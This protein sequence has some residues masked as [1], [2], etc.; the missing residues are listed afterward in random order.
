M[1]INTTLRFLLTHSPWLSSSKQTTTNAEE[2]VWEKVTFIHCWW[3]SKCATTVNI[4]IKVHQKTKHRTTVWPCCTLLECISTYKE[5]T[6]T[7]IFVELLI[8]IVKLLNQCRCPTTNEWIKKIHVYTMEYYSVI[9]KNEF[10][11]FAEKWKE[12]EIIL[13][14][15]ICQSQKFKYHILSLICGL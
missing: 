12:L 5:G 3:E 11:S 2:D 13:L 7:P 9:N 14:R 4:N 10:I 6:S 1:Q 8:I 15:K